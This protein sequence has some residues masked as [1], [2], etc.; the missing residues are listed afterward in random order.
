MRAGEAI[1]VQGTP[2]LCTFEFHPVEPH[3]F[4]C[5]ILNVDFQEHFFAFKGV[6][7]GRG[8]FG[9]VDFGL[10]GQG[11]G[12]LSHRH[13]TL[14]THIHTPQKKEK[15]DERRTTTHRKLVKFPK[16]LQTRVVRPLHR[17]WCIRIP[18]R[19]SIRDRTCQ[20]VLTELLHLMMHDM[21]EPVS[22]RKRISS[23][24][25]LAQE[26]LGARGLHLEAD[27]GALYRCMRFIVNRERAGEG[28]AELD[29]TE[30]GGEGE[31]FG[32]VCEIAQGLWVSG[33][34]GGA[35]EGEN[36]RGGVGGEGGRIGVE[37][38]PSSRESGSLVR[39][40]VMSMGSFESEATTHRD[41]HHLQR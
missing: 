11:I 23:S 20:Y 30:C 24:A 2:A 19:K 15:D 21:L 28:F 16:A 1:G 14:S 29:G 38:F 5:H 13:A 39:A 8:G 6:K 40:N 33:E 4:L 41:P 9:G 17:S 36:G 35:L 37:G 32:G 25:E 22:R 27:M 12:D 3:G 26:G 34:R 10:D 31:K 7:E 18:R